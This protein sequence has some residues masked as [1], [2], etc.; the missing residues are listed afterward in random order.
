MGKFAKWIGGGLGFAFFGPIGAI[1]GFALGSF[2]DV[3]NQPVRRPIAG[4][5]T[6]GDFAVSLLV[7]IAAMMKADGRVLQSELNYVKDYFRRQFDDESA[8]EAVMLLRDILKQ[9]IPIH[10]VCNQIS[11]NLDYASRLQLMHFLFGIA[12]ADGHVH[13]REVELAR[14]IAAWLG[15]SPRDLGS[16]EN[17]FVKNPAVHYKILGLE[18][19]ATN[20]EVKKAY[21]E[22][23]K[24]FHPDKVAYLGEE[25]KKAAE[26]KFKKIN[27]AYE[28]VK[29]ERGM[30]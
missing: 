6:T 27:E 19:S 25:M 8:G 11:L 9:S 29:K 4:R 23:A 24:Q 18:P 13:P 1:M 2:I 15:I 22:M 14:Q 28:A 10:D 17:M 20:D 21:R 5:A 26:E 30:A 16:V 3:A 12:N 7:L